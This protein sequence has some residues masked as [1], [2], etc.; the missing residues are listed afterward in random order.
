M[1]AGLARSVGVRCFNFKG[2]D[3]EKEKLD[4]G[5]LNI[6]KGTTIQCKRK[7]LKRAPPVKENTTDRNSLILKSDIYKKSKHYQPSRVE[8]K[9]LPLP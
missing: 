6:K 8:L 1:E 7:Q 4:V 2:Q 5:V 3:E 9:Q